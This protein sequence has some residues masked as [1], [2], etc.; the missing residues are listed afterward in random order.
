ME[1]F[2]FLILLI[3]KFLPALD[4]LTIFLVIFLFIKQTIKI[5]KARLLIFVN[6][7]IFSQKYY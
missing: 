7:T 2:Y 6:S 3:V 4:E 5:K 1:F